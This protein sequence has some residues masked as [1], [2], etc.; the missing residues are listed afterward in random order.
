MVEII[1]DSRVRVSLA[2][3]DP[4]VAEAIRNDFTHRNP[5]WA[6]LKAMGYWSKEPKLYET[7][8]H[9]AGFLTLPRGGFR[10]VRETFRDFGVPWTWTD[11][12]AG[13]DPS[14]GVPP[15]HRRQ[16]YDYQ[17]R[18]KLAALAKENC[19]VRMPT[20]SGK[21]TLSIALAA[22]FGT[23]TMI[24]VHTNGLRKQWVDRLGEEMGLD[25]SDVGVVQA[26][27][28]KLRPVTL[29]M[30]QTLNKIPPAKWEQMNAYFGAVVFDEVHLFAANTFLASADKCAARFRIGVS[31]DERRSDRKEFLVYDVF[32]DM[33]AEVTLE[34]LVGR[35]FV[36]D[37][38][39]V[40]EPTSFRADWYLDQKK[41]VALYDDGKTFDEVFS[42][43]SAE[44]PGI[45]PD[46]VPTAKRPDFGRLI[47][48]M[49]ADEDRNNRILDLAAGLARDG[50]R[51]LVFSH[52]VE[53]CERIAAGIVARGVRCGLLLGG[54]RQEE[55]DRTIARL[56]S[57]DAVVGVGTWQAMGTG[58]DLPSIDRGIM[59]TPVQNSKL[60]GQMRGR[61]CRTANG[62]KDAIAHVMWDRFV[63]GE[64]QARNMA[65]WNSVCKVRAESGLVE[66][67]R[68][69]SNG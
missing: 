41:A 16:L 5:K 43:F 1:V 54:D 67:R 25:R 12:R 20:G 52:R 40:L 9:E 14:R 4:R 69:L 30:Q 18:G 38:D 53:H 21:S 47:E 60:W 61:L 22:E 50:H 28:F 57:G 13:G 23:P 39:V 24:V 11:R 68:Y 10:R 62:K 42:A 55:F 49:C 35:A 34:E 7:W 32:G 36:H 15:A 3:I 31:A 2:D 26:K 46:E 59:T 17:A 63:F 51:A 65:A 56:K 8:R 58:I 64:Q 19:L 45:K 44:R 48:E 27:E 29:A 33:A 37:V 66:V 6:R